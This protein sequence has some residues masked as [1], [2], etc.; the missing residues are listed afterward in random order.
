MKDKTVT[1]LSSV[2][3]DEYAKIG[4]EWKITSCRTEFKTAL[5]CSYASGTLEAA[6][7]AKS[8][9]GAVEYPSEP[10]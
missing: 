3:H 5:H 9:A 4:G 6:L 7:A 1:F 8:V 2:Y 10:A